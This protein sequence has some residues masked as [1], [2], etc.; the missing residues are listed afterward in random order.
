MKPLSKLFYFGMILGGF[1]ISLPLVL[2]LLAIGAEGRGRDAE[3]VPFLIP[4]AMLPFIVMTAIAIGMLVYKMWS[5]IQVGGPAPRTTPGL[6]VGLLFVPCFNYYWVFQ[7][8]WGWTKDFN[9]YTATTNTPAPRMPEGLALTICIFLVLSIIP[10]VGACLGL[11]NMVLLL[12]F[13]NSAIN[14]VNAVIAARQGGMA[15][16]M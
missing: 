7:A 13:V 15:P 2:I 1:L 4:I 16:A 11:V 12:M 9:A 3:I 8:Y 6:A 5:V 14:G 10:I